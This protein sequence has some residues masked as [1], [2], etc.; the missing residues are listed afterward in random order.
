M[1]TAT[2]AWLTDPSEIMAE[3]KR[4]ANGA[5]DAGADRQRQALVAHASKLERQQR[6]ITSR[7]AEA[8]DAELARQLN[9]RW[10]E[11]QRERD[12]VG[13]EIAALIRRAADEAAV[14]ANLRSVAAYARRVAA[15]I[16]TFGFEERRATLMAL[17]TRVIAAGN[18]PSEWMLAGAIPTH[19]EGA[20]ATAKGRCARPP[21]R[22]Q[23]R[24]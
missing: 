23:E 18:E 11:A 13:E 6:T 4:R 12:R 10:T 3:L 7:I 1:W 16:A 22:P 19:I 9:E 24:A 15:G 20:L 2:D 17:A 21:R 8:D 5:P 14:V